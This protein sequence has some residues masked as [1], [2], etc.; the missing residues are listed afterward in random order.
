MS[1]RASSFC[2][3]EIPRVQ[4]IGQRRVSGEALW[5]DQRVATEDVAADVDAGPGKR[6]VGPWCMG[7]PPRRGEYDPASA[8]TNIGPLGLG[9]SGLG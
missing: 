3:K 6:L 2:V 1:N 5:F 8:P 7:R 4:R 9:L